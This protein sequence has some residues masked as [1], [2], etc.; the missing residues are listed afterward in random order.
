MTQKNKKPISHGIEVPLENI[1][2][3]GVAPIK[4]LLMS[5]IGAGLIWGCI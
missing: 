1:R 3:Y 5:G 2:Y 4:R